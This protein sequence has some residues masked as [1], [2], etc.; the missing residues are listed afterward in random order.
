M[1][2]YKHLTSHKSDTGA[3]VHWHFKLVL[4][5]IRRKITSKQTFRDPFTVC[6]TLL[7]NPDLFFQAYRAVRDYTIQ[8]GIKTEC[9]KTAKKKVKSYS[10]QFERLGVFKFHI[11]KLSNCENISYYL[12]KTFKCG[13]KG[14]VDVSQE[15]PAI[16]TYKVST[17]TLTLKCFFTYTNSYGH[18]CSY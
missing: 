15:K 3:L 11:A 2:T 8:L 6:V 18:I 5:S 7:I 10:I 16:L 4:Q 12:K 14:A 1:D 17:G 9:Q 13:G